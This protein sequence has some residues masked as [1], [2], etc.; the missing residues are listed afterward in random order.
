MF[1]LIIVIDLHPEIP[2]GVGGAWLRIVLGHPSRWWFSLGTVDWTR[3][4]SNAAAVQV[5]SSVGPRMQM[6]KVQ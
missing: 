4:C 6:A 5:Y 3:H 1:I 2:I